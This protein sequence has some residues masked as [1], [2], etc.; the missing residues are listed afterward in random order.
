L[1]EDA[2]EHNEDAREHNEGA[3]EPNEGAREPNEGARKPNEC[4]IHVAPKRLYTYMYVQPCSRTNVTLLRFGLCVFNA[5]CNNISIISR[6]VLNTT[7]CEQVCQCA[8]GRS[9]VFS[10]F[11]H[12]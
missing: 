9:V 12:Q 11:L 3:R 7:L 1:N 10:G 6:G 5:T 2:R 4:E 8:S